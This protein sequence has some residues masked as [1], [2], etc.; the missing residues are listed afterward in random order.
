MPIEAKRPSVEMTDEQKLVELQNV[1]ATH[2]DSMDIAAV[3]KLVD[4]YGAY[5]YDIV[6][7]ALDPVSLVEHTDGQYRNTRYAIAYFAEKDINAEKLAAIVG[8]DDATKVQEKLNQYETA[9]KQKLVDEAY[10]QACGG[11]EKDKV[12]IND[13]MQQAG[14][15]GEDFQ[16][17]CNENP[18]LL[19][20]VGGG[21]TCEALAKAA[22]DVKTKYVGGKAQVGMCKSGVDAIH[23]NAASKY[24]LP[25]DSLHSADSTK[26]I[27]QYRKERPYQG[28]SNG[29]C[30]LYAGLESSNDYVTVAVKNEAYRKTK[31]GQED[32]RMNQLLLQCQPGVT[33]TVD[34][35]EDRKIAQAQTAGGKWGHTVVRANKTKSA[36][37]PWAC[38]FEQGDI[39]FPRYGEYAHV[40]FPKD[41][42]VSKDY[43][44]ML[45]EKAM[46]RP[47]N[48]QTNVQEQVQTATQSSRTKIE[49][50]K[51]KGLGFPEADTVQPVSARI[52]IPEIPVPEFANVGDK[53][54]KEKKAR[55]TKQEMSTQE[56]KL[57]SDGNDRKAS[58]VAIK[59][60]AVAVATDVR[61]VLKALEQPT[62]ET[63][64]EALS[65]GKELRITS[66]G[67]IYAVQTG[68]KTTETP[69][70]TEKPSNSAQLL[71]YL[72]GMKQKGM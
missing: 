19:G 52:S 55:E 50:G 56:G 10:L 54:K 25:T 40:C 11:E 71:A 30:N 58:F 45:I 60:G 12:S 53:K 68:E 5:A 13:L 35:V 61:A 27:A 46:N 41:A 9:K 67:E 72:R 16:A 23:Y 31:G 62:N 69:T 63:V 17:V 3:D 21:K 24:G 37:R 2:S 20:A 26:A 32:K 4:K 70:P 28:S 44:K 29:G 34:A 59:G 64:R 57:P 42:Y 22:D 36:G 7:K 51:V 49:M 48:E 6:Y 39:N 15:R 1:I 8:Y 38:D 43:A 33:V 66:K 14:V 65:A 47:A 18:E